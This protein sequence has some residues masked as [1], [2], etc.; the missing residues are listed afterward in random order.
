MGGS[1][2]V[3]AGWLT[4]VEVE[5]DVRVFFA[6]GGVVVGSAFYAVRFLTRQYLRLRLRRRRGGEEADTWTLRSLMSADGV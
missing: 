5:V 6:F 2:L 3:G 4:G 1:G